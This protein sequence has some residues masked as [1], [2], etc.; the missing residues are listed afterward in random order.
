MLNDFI[1]NNT[2]HELY[3]DQGVIFWIRYNGAPTKLYS[4]YNI[5]LIDLLI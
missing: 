5:I 1:V 2:M 4:I 3:F